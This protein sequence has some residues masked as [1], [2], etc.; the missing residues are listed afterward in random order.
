[1]KKLEKAFGFYPEPLEMKAGSIKVSPL[2]KFSSRVAPV[3]AHENV[4][5]DWIYAPLQQTSDFMSGKIREQPYSSRV[6]RLPKT[7]MIEHAKAT[8]DEH[9]DFLI[10]ALSFFVGMRLTATEAGFLDATPVKTGKLVDFM[11][12]ADVDPD[13]VD[14]KRS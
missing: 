11:L 5:D 12:L 13:E 14:S 9:L 2:P 3:P 1:M 8:G 6:F 10:W 4:K 7:H